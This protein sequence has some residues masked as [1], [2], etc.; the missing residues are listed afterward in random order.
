VFGIDDKKAADGCFAIVG[1]QRTGSHYADPMFSGLVQMDSVL[2]IEF[3][4]RGQNAFFVD[5]VNYELQRKPPRR[6]QHGRREL[7]RTARRSLLGRE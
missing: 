3:G 5:S 2:A 7:K 4:A 1:D 6:W